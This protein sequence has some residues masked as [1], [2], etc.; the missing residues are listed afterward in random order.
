MRKGDCF[1]GDL[2]FKGNP[3]Y[4][5]VLGEPD[6]AGKIALV[7]FTTGCGGPKAQLMPKI[8]CP[9]L[10]YDS[11]I[12]WSESVIVAAGGIDLAI[13][14]TKFESKAAMASNVVDII[15]AEGLVKRLIPKEVVRFLGL[16]Y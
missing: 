10:E 12:A 1:H 5:V 14:E 11:E 15:L 2:R 8:D 4:W 9:A 13:S 7:N 16:K 6:K 3:H